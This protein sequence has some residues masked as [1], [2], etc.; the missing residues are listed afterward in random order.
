MGGFVVK[1]SMIRRYNTFT[2]SIIATKQTSVLLTPRKMAF[3][4][5]LNEQLFSSIIMY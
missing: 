4:H 1:D 3:L 5:G 2:I